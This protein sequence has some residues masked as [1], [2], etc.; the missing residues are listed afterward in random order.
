MN[1]YENEET[2]VG[3]E[4][5]KLKSLALNLRQAGSGASLNTLF[6]NSQRAIYIVHISMA[7][8]ALHH[9][10]RLPFP[11]PFYIS[12]VLQTSTAKCFRAWNLCR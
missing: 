7:H 9:D 2:T 1:A 11:T 4:G 10:T 3:R 8:P 6:H 5:L 12:I